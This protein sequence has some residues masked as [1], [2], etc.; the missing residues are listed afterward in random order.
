MGWITSPLEGEVET[1]GD[2]RAS[3]VGGVWK[4]PGHEFA[5][6][7]PSLTL[8]LIGVRGVP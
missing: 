5:E 7:P 3:R 2:S 8:P 4:I 1:A 6:G